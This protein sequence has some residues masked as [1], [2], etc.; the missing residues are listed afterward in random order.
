MPLFCASAWYLAL[1]APFGS[2][3]FSRDANSLG[4]FLIKNLIT[5]ST[6]SR[7]L[8]EHFLHP[9]SKAS[10]TWPGRTMRF[11]VELFFL[12]YKIIW[13]LQTSRS[14]GIINDSFALYLKLHLLYWHLLT[15][16]LYKLPQSSKTLFKNKKNNIFLEVIIE[17]SRNCCNQIDIS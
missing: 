6:P 8:G 2:Y 13:P 14:T 1:K 17:K 16:V 5:F 10:L 9:D 12:Q 7:C 11:R 3:F 15:P 4:L